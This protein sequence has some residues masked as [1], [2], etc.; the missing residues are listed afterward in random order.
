METRFTVTM[1]NNHKHTI[2]LKSDAS[3]EDLADIINNKSDYNFLT[4]N[5][6]DLVNA[7]VYKILL[8]ISN[9]ISIQ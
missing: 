4:F 9:I 7:R 6:I 8:K 2:T 3:I 1:I 5:C